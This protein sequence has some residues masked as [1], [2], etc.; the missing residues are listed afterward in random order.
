MG[1]GATST[2]R[3]ARILGPDL[4]ERGRAN[5]LSCPMY[6]SGAL[7]APDSATI[8]IREGSTVRVDAA[9]AP[10]SGSI[11]TYT[12]TPAASLTLGEGWVVQW[13]LTYGSE[14]LEIVNEAALVRRRLHPVVTDADLFRRVPALDP[15][16]GA[17]ITSST[18][19]QDFLD[20]AWAEV[21]QRLID[22]GNRPNLIMSASA[23]RRV[24][25]YLTLALIFEDL[26]TRLR[27]DYAEQG[28]R[29][30]ALYTDAW[31]DLRFIY[32]EDDD[33]VAEEPTRRRAARPV[34]WLGGRA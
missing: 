33:G 26:A 32:D 20:E 15:A 13:N 34:V 28:E 5:A 9:A 30:R 19:F 4:L 24:H 10:I 16:G 12:Y 27:E 22:Q 11:A 23:T 7:V 21:Q 8:T 29:Y 3:T 17:P 14:E 6:A 25:L 18:D 31:R 1:A 2:H